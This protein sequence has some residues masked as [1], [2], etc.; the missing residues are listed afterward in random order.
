VATDLVPNRLADISPKAYEHP[1]DRAATA[2]LKAVPMLD[3]VIRRLIEFQYERALRQSL[4]ASSVKL[5]DDQLPEVW[6]GYQGVLATLDMP[7]VYDL[8]LTQWPVANAAAIGAGKPMI[9]V[10]SHLVELLDDVELKTV[11]AHE[12]GHILSE[13]VVY[14]TAL[15][16]LLQLGSSVRLPLLAGL[17]LLAVR[18]SLLEWF[19]ASEL[20]CDRA[21]TLVNRDP[22]VTCRALMVLAGGRGSKKL[23]LDAF[24]RQAA[25]YEDW[26]PGLDRMRRFFLEL[27]LSHS[28]PVRR[29][30][31]L[32]KWV[33]SG[34]YDRIVRGDYPKRGEDVDAR[35][36]ASD[37]V[38]YY[39][40]R[41]RTIF[42][43][44][45][46]NV[47]AAGERF[48]EWLRGGDRS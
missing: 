41:F 22:L 29:V 39:S 24:L 46:E 18:A 38:E 47:A 43:E 26:E 6:Q 2:A 4:L 1:A 12:A 16:I 15:L 14:R 23:N 33:R 36:H 35:A 3:T 42:R 7:D 40:D 5:G 21:A 45:G 17:P 10:N 28:F 25:E 30:S 8:Y 11:L 31:E 48:S 27:Q 37:A 32:Q 34:E 9:V 20:S 13:H 44:T 19:R